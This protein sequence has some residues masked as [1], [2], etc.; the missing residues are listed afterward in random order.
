MLVTRPEFR[1]KDILPTTDLQILLTVGCDGLGPLMST[2]IQRLVEK[3]CGCSLR[4]EQSEYQ[5]VR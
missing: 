5:H 2:K 3:G 1:A 4:A